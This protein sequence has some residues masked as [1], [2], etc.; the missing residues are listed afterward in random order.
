MFLMLKIFIYNINLVKIINLLNIK[1][2]YL[3]N[4]TLCYNIK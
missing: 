2:Y 3:I 4:G 1:D